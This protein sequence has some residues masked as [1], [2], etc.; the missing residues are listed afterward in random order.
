MQAFEVA[1]ENLEKLVASDSVKETVEYGNS[2]RYP[3][4]KWETVVET[5][6]EPLTNR[7]WVRGVCS[8]EY[9][10][11]Q[12]ETQTIELTHWL[13]DVTKQQLLQLANQEEQAQE[14]MAGELI[15]TV[16]EAAEYAGV[17]VETIEQWLDEGMLQT[18]DGSFV[19]GN[20]DLYVRT[21]GKPS[22]E[23]KDQQ[24]KSTAELLDLAK[25]EAGPKSDAP[26]VPGS[27]SSGVD[28]TTG[29]TYEELEAMDFDEVLQ[30]LQK[31][32]GKE[33]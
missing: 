18:E 32:Q 10:D 17:G 16:E 30:L 3:D 25:G 29:L 26:S 11:M 31:K 8:A 20:L 2:D 5:F 14:Q 24:V 7:M 4:I 22:A 19:K 12:G 33:F 27:Q 1:R 9:E 6:Y 21:G 15:E 23:E 13:T 28:P